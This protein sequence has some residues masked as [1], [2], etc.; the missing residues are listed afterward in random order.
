MK[1]RKWNNI[2]HRD[3][4]YLFFG[5][6]VIYAI[7][8]ITAN[9]YKE[10]NSNFIVE[11]KTVQLEKISPGAQVDRAMIDGILTRL[12]ETDNYK[13]HFRATPSKLQIF[14]HD[15][16]VD[17]DL[18][19]MSAF[20]EKKKSRPVLREFNFLHLNHAKKLWTWVA[21]IYAFGLFL[22]AVTGLFVLKG[23]K[24][25][26]GRGKWFV[27]AGIILPIAFLFLYFY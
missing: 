10:W 23:K 24:G 20:M 27:A 18:N 13:A 22:L 3:L 7:S 19:K 21:D 2:V 6:T 15:G 11:Q 8:G 5:L 9:H 16:T 12:G 1:W 26:S 17:V 4:G 25:F 14:I